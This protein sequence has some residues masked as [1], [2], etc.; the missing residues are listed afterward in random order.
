MT[1]RVG[2]V[3]RTMRNAVQTIFNRKESPRDMQERQDLYMSIL[4]AK[5]RSMRLQRRIG[6]EGAETREQVERLV[7]EAVAQLEESDAATTPI[8]GLRFEMQNIL[9]PEILRA[10]EVFRSVDESIPT[11]ADASEDIRSHSKDDEKFQSILM[12]EYEQVQAQL[13]S[14][15]PATKD[16]ITLNKPSPIP[17]LEMKS[18][19]LRTV[20]LSRGWLDIDDQQESISTDSSS[21]DGERNHVPIADN[22]GYY[23]ENADDEINAA[24]RH[25]QMINLAKTALIREQLGFSVLS[26]KSTIPEAGRGIFVDGTALAGS[27][28]AFFPGQI[29]PKE[30]LSNAAFSTAL[31]KDD[32]NYQLSIR[33]DDILID[34]RKAPYTVLNDANCN[35]WAVAHI[36]NH[37]PKDVS[38]NCRTV[39]VNFTEKMKLDKA[40]LERYIPNTYAREP[41]VTGPRALDRDLIR[42]HGF[43]IMAVRD[44][45]SEELFYDYRLSP[46]NAYPKWYHPCDEEGLKRRWWEE[47]Q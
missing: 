30:Y 1:S 18:G 29:W 7:D 11:A 45:S 44:V 43:G 47:E 32:N 36:A 37:P 17:Y 19:A 8:V 2:G 25:Y 42:M 23:A 4:S 6:S 33:Y 41:M 14:G 21:T 16:Q 5:H 39:M 26:L 12:S 31:F 13:S 24:I 46:G 35:P 38:A 22:F 20:L 34:S 40:G 9:A 27:L 10:F 15:D 28:L 3:L